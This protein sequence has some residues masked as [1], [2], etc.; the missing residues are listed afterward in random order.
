MHLDEILSISL[1]FVLIIPGEGSTGLSVAAQQ[2]I[3]SKEMT[4]GKCLDFFG[5]PFLHFFL[6]EMSPV[7][8]SNSK[9]YYKDYVT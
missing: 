7:I 8:V 9:Y 4:L 1:D 5:P 3:S 6:C 2:S